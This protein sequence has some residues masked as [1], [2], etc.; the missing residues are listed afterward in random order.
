MKISDLN[1]G[2][3]ILAKKVRVS[4]DFYPDNYIA[5]IVEKGRKYIYFQ[6]HG[7]KIKREK[8]D[9]L[10]SGLVDHYVHDYYLFKDESQFAEYQKAKEARNKLREYFFSTIN[11]VGKLS[12][13]QVEQINRIIRL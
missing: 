5:T 10:P 1:V 2:D 6:V 3:T 7:I 12:D 4:G 13:Q 9:V 11:A 8:N